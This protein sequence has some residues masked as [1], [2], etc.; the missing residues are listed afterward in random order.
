M[1]LCKEA[2]TA[3]KAD[4]FLEKGASKV[5][6]YFIKKDSEYYTA[7]DIYGD[8]GRLLL[9]KGQKVTDDVKKRLKRLGKSVP[10]KS[11]DTD[12]IKKSRPCSK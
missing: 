9:S 7:Q 11:N 12:N 4:I 1:A 5:S 3:L 10:E 8:K 6:E 2:M